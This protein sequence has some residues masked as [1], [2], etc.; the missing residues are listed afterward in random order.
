MK[1]S[2]LIVLFVLLAATLPGPA[3]RGEEGEGKGKK[4]GRALYDGMIASFRAA[5]SL[6]YECSVQSESEE[7]TPRGAYRQRIEL[8]KP[9]LARVEMVAWYGNRGERAVQEI[10]EKLGLE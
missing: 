3:A 8:A 10:W 2:R 6:R 9:N 5:K 7:G 1:I 4:D